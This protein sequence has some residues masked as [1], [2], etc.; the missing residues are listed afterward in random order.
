MTSFNAQ[1]K[2]AMEKSIL[3]MVQDGGMVQ[4][5]HRDRMKLPDGFMA[6]VWGLVDLEK[7]KAQMAKRLEEELA[8]R[9]VNHMAAELATDVKQ[10]L[11]VKERREALRAV[12]RENMERICGGKL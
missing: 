10:I 12:A 1:L 2:E 4:P 8:N 6:D 3:K 5:N 9:V 11:S 7:I